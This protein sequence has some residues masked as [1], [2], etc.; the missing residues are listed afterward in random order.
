[1]V[2]AQVMSGGHR[3]FGNTLVLQGRKQSKH[4]ARLKVTFVLAFIVL[5]T[6]ICQRNYWLDFYLSGSTYFC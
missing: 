3:T 2:C 1:M 5:K 4:M 6:R